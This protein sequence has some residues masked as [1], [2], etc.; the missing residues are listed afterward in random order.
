ME[1]TAAAKP[2]DRAI[3]ALRAREPV[4][5]LDGDGDV[6]GL[7]MA[8]MAADHADAETLLRFSRLTGGWSYLALTDEKCEQLGL[9]LTAARDDELVHA[10]LTATIKARDGVTTGVSFA[11]RA[12][13]I[14]VATD[15]GSRSKDIRF[16]GNVLPLRSRPGGVLERAGYTEAAIDLVRSADLGPAALLGEMLAEDGTE[17]GGDELAR[18][19]ER[20]GV[21]AITIAEI[22]AH[23]RRIEPLVRRVVSTSLATQR[24]QYTAFGYLGAL[25]NAE[26]MAL[27]RG[28]ID[29]DVLVYIHLACWE[30]DVFRSRRCQ[31]R[32]RL[33]AAEAAIAEAGSGVIVHLAHAGHLHHAERDPDA[34]IRDFGVGAQVLADLGIT[35]IRVLTD[36]ARPL[37]GLEGYGLEVTGNAPLLG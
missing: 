27:V 2:I 29:D 3:A 36:R 17:L 30:G 15:P 34:Q 23:R 16:G 14:R 21:A 12:Q 37:V 22:I 5:V 10:P 20:E 24:G 6:G 26:H 32:A 25:D 28:E 13:T 8:V 33:D 7:G 35:R 1:T 9:H 18:F 11:E 4:L 31:C 19:A